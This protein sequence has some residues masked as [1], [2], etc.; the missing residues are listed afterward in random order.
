VWRWEH[1]RLK[2]ATTADGLERV[3]A[4]FADIEMPEPVNG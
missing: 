4:Q 3:M 1:R 2:I